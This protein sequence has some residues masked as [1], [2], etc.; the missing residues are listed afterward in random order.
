MNS[1]S[2]IEQVA[3]GKDPKE[4]FQLGENEEAIHRSGMVD[5]EKDAKK[6][7]DDFSDVAAS[8]EMLVDENPDLPSGKRLLSDLE[9]I[10]SLLRQTVAA[11]SRV[12]STIQREWRK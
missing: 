5:F 4:V 9:K 6:L 7:Y 2:L 10:E 11:I 12:S 1:K 3:S 8:I